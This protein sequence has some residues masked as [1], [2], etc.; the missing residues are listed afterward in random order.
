MFYFS[1]LMKEKCILPMMKIMNVQEEI[2]LWSKNVKGCPIANTSQC[3]R[4]LIKFQELLTQ[5]LDR[6]LFRI[7]EN[8]I[9]DKHFLAKPWNRN[10]MWIWKKEAETI[11]LTELIPSTWYDNVLLKIPFWSREG[12]VL[13]TNLYIKTVLEDMT[14]WNAKPITSKFYHN[15]WVAK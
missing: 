10:H 14:S 6:F 12:K 3:W 7:T 15:K 4:L 5:R 1:S 11:S 13:A 2:L 8:D 9:C